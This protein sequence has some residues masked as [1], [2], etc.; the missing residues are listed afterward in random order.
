MSE[1]IQVDGP[2]SKYVR[3]EKREPLTLDGKPKHLVMKS[4]DQGEMHW[5]VNKVPNNFLDLLPTDQEYYLDTECR[6]E[7]ITQEELDQM[8]LNSYR[9]MEGMSKPA[10]KAELIR[11]LNTEIDELNARIAKIN[12]V[13]V[14]EEEQKK[15]EEEL[16]LDK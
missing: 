7:Y 15:Y 14:T 2:G 1:E 8:T 11:E 12:E 9:F 3:N 13:M 5:E 4:Y 16:A 10:S 6:F